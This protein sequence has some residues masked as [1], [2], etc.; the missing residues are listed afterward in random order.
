MDQRDLIDGVA[1]ALVAASPYV[2]VTGSA[3][4]AEQ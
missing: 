4:L 3:A 1:A 2:Q